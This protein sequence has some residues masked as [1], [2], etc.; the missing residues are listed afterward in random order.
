M[1]ELKG[2]DEN[3]VIHCETHFEDARVRNILSFFKMNWANGE[4][5]RLH[6]NWPSFGQNTCIYPNQGVS[7]HLNHAR[8]DC[9]YILTATEFIRLNTEPTIPEV[10]EWLTLYNYPYCDLTSKKV[11]EREI[12]GYEPV[13]EFHAPFWNNVWTKNNN[14]GY[15][16]KEE[17]HIHYEIFERMIEAGIFKPVYR[18]K[19]TF[20]VGDIITGKDFEEHRKVFVVKEVKEGMVIIETDGEGTFYYFRDCRLATPEEMEAARPKEVWERY[21]TW[22]SLPASEAFYHNTSM[23]E[24]GFAS[25][26][27][28]ESAVSFAMLSQIEKAWNEGKKG[29]WT[30]LWHSGEQK[31]KV[32]HEE[33][34]IAHI[35]FASEK[36]AEKSLEL[37]GDLWRKFYMV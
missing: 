32:F 8:Q 24:T 15:S 23:H 11:E 37:H 26:K 10:A 3:T 33:F 36:L 14:N 22:E 1:K 17:E 34:F 4:S 7:I 6:S 25:L 31:L 28:S 5:F 13:N 19:A 16:C 21:P 2:I 30:V 29:S 12:I 20:K 35:N 9:R 18:E 27:H